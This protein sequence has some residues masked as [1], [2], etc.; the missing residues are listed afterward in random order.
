MTN[1]ASLFYPKS[2]A[3]IG[4]TDSP[5]KLGAIVLGNLIRMKGAVYPVNPK[6]H[7]IMGLKAYP[8][9]EDVPGT[10]DLSIILRPAVEIPEML[11][12]HAGK[13]RIALIVSAGFAEIGATE[14]QEEVARIARELGVRLVGP[15]CLG[16]YNPFHRLDTMFLPHTCLKRPVKGNVAVVSQSG[17]VMVSLLDALRQARTGVSKV[18]NYGNAVDIDASDMFDYLAGDVKTDVA[19]CYLESVG[20]GRRFI[21]AARRLADSKAVILLKAGKGLSG[22][23]AAFS[24]TG[25]LA[26]SYEVFRSVLRQFRITEAQDFDSL[27]DATKALSFQKPLPGRRVCIITNG[28][29]AGVLASDECA[30]HGLEVNPV[31]VEMAHRLKACFPSFYV[32]GNPIDLTGQVKTG[33][34]RIALDAV[35]DAYDGFVVIILTGVPGLTLELADIIRDFHVKYGKPLV[36]HVA[37]GGIA[38]RLTRL[39]EKSKVPVY[40][41]P[42][43]AIR[44]LA[45]LLGGDG[46]TRARN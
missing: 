9:I 31:P 13:A 28:G 10:V 18:L 42:E 1:L 44:G 6:Y 40:G 14:L 17:A 43:R 26:G 11:R 2:V 19:V 32:V 41:S 5:G 25:R 20:D 39:L 27:L 33:D 22:Q 7:E 37:Q 21:A 46:N 4:A 15:N 34:Y 12:Q 24:H 35:R 36:A 29:G 45:M 38:P 30:R 8:S 16:I 23:A 3:L